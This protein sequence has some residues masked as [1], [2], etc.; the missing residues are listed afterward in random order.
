MTN[1]S[2][3]YS[4]ILKDCFWE[5][6]LNKEKIHK[7][8]TSG[9][10]SEKKF[11]FE[12]ILLNS[13]EVFRALEIFNPEDLKVLIEDFKV[14]EFNYDFIFKRKNIVE[15]Y[16]LDKPLLIKELQWTV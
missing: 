4:Q 12:K 2:E 13:T 8:S 5:Y 9:E 14:P 3:I 1:Q 15:V 11:L 16:F 6:N 7:L 10:F